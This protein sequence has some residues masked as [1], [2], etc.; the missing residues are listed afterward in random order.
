MGGWVG[1]FEQNKHDGVGYGPM[2]LVLFCPCMPAL[3]ARR[4]EFL[5]KD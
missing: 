4:N 1:P 2:H 5:S 3:E